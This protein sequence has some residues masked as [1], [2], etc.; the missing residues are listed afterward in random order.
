ML[1]T[2]ELCLRAVSALHA[3]KRVKRTEN[4]TNIMFFYLTN[5]SVRRERV[6]K[7]RNG[8][9][10]G[11][12]ARETKNR[13]AITGKR[14]YYS[15]TVSL[16]QRSSS[17]VF[18]FRQFPLN[19]NGLSF[20]LESVFSRS[21]LTVFPLTLRRP[22]NVPLRVSDWCVH[23]PRNRVRVT[24]RRVSWHSMRSMIDAFVFVVSSARI[25]F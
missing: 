2:L 24:K 4:A 5:F 3:L 12:N 17:A 16:G 20:S 18:L 7:L 19:V 15:Y 8:T 21:H 14:E 11:C 6:N 13:S 25:F 9:R 10:F 1:N 23:K 22:K